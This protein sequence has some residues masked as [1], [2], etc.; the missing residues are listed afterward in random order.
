MITIA[1]RQAASAR[2][3]MAFTMGRGAFRVVLEG[4]GVWVT[5][6]SLDLDMPK[7]TEGAVNT[8]GGSWTRRVIY[9]E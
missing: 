5:F 1:Q 8:G 6:P 9:K 3:Y 7:N 2:R 4:V